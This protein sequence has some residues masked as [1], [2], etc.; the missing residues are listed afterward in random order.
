[1]VT[2]AQVSW[3]KM[4]PVLQNPLV[5]GVFM[6]WTMEKM[7]VRFLFVFISADRA[8]LGSLAPELPAHLRAKTIT[9][10][11]RFKPMTTDDHVMTLM[12]MLP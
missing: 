1:M 12:T 5:N 10:H 7:Q 2:D 8:C 9:R 6:E 3:Y 11:G 4:R